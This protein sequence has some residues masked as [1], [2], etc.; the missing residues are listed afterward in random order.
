MNLGVY[1]KAVPVLK[2]F[3]LL[4]FYLSGNYLVVRELAGVL[5]N[6]E[7]PVGTEI[8]LAPFFYAFT[9]AVPVLYIV[10]ALRQKSR[11]LLWIGLLALAFSVFT[12]RYYHHFLPPAVAL[13]LGGVLLFMVAYFAIKKLKDKTTGITFQ[14]DRSANGNL[15]MAE[16]L[17]TVAQFG[18]KAAVASDSNSGFG[19]GG[20]SG[21][22]SEGGY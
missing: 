10:Y 3:S 17:I 13:T 6:T 8:P 7:I 20:F 16:T 21:G 12:I 4:L 9:L 18:Q 19:G 1:H 2:G 15:A 11:L 14:P 22:G 5:L